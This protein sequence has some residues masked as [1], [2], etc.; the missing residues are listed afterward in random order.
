[1]LNPAATR[2]AVLRARAAA[3]L[4]A[5][6][7]AQ[8][9]DP[10]YLYTATEFTMANLQMPGEYEDE[11]A[12]VALVGAVHAVAAH[13]GVTVVDLGRDVYTALV[14]LGAADRRA[15]ML[16]CDCEEQ[17]ALVRDTCDN[18]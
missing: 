6:A 5:L 2:T 17:I 10:N 8:Q 14:A 18:H 4:A 3:D 9:V 7:H 1:M 11:L 12:L 16:G 13:V 15:A